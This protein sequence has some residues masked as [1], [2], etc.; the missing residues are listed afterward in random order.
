MTI[1][2]QMVLHF[3]WLIDAGIGQSA[4]NDGESDDEMTAMLSPALIK[5]PIKPSQSHSQPAL[6]V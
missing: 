2:K 3:V 1:F 5:R 4:D 6:F